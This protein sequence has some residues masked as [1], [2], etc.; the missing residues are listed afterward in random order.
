MTFPL[1]SLGS[2]KSVPPEV[3]K[4]RAMFAA[5]PPANRMNAGTVDRV[6]SPEETASSSYYSTETGTVANRWSNESGKTFGDILRNQ[7]EKL[8]A[9]GKAGEFSYRRNFPTP[10]EQ[11]EAFGRAAFAAYGEDWPKL[12]DIARGAAIRAHGDAMG[13]VK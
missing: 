10:E 2:D 13:E 3:M 12:M 8:V 9:D 7:H 6:K 4:N 11:A 5:G 1:F